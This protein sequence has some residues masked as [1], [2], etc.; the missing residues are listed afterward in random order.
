[1]E[2]KTK[3]STF[4]AKRVSNETRVE[5]ELKLSP[6]EINLNSGLGFLDHLLTSLAHHAGWSLSLSCEGDLDVDDHHSAED[7]AIT[8]GAVLAAAVA[9]R[10]AIA[11]FGSAYAPLDEALARAVVDVSGRAWASIDLGL[12]REK[13]GDLSAENVGHFLES[14]AANAGLCLHVDVLKGE[15]DHHRA[16]A[17][18]K[19]L[20]LAL[21]EALAPLASCEGAKS[22]GVNSTKG[23]A[24][25]SVARKDETGTGYGS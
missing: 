2:T 1:M 23:P 15:N 19:A 14:F 21:K 5:I 9:E 7:I 25:L 17:A 10:G 18:F 3:T 24:V 4:A 12:E 13:L 20:A 16:E 22:G 6:G 11:R 8:L